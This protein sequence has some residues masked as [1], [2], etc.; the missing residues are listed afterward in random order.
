MKRIFL[1]ITALVIAFST[2]ANDEKPLVVSAGNVKN[3]VLGNDMHVTLINAASLKNEINTNL[4]DVFDKLNIEVSNGNMR[5][6]MRPKAGKNERVYIIVDDLRSLTVGEN[7]FVEAQ[8]FLPG[9]QIKIVIAD[10]SYVRLLTN[11]TVKAYSLDGLSIDIKT[12][13][14]SSQKN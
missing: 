11:A 14:F 3:I 1:I 12:K 13:R 9:R 4:V 8:D 2:F 5:I 10:Q 7:T 6:E